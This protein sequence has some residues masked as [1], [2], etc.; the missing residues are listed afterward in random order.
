MLLV[1]VKLNFFVS[2]WAYV[3]YSLYI[4]QNNFIKNVASKEI[5]IRSWSGSLQHHYYHHHHHH[6]HHTLHSLVVAVGV[7]VT[8]GLVPLIII[9]TQFETS[10][11]FPS[12]LGRFQKPTARLIFFF[13][14]NHSCWSKVCGNQ[15]LNPV[16]EFKI[17]DQERERGEPYLAQFKST[18]SCWTDPKCNVQCSAF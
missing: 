7:T 10:H 12:L 11:L 8:G 16:M 18:V 5:M 14:E 1:S 2:S 9:W 4:F 17:Q 13:N 15:N 3:N 6:H